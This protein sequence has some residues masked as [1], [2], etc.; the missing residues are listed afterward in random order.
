MTKYGRE[1]NSWWMVLIMAFLALSI[2]FVSISRASLEIATSIDNRETLRKIPIECGDF[3]YKLPHARTLPTSKIY[4]L[5]RF[6]DW[7]WLNFTSEAK[8]KSEVALFIAD[9]KMAEALRLFELG[10][11]KIALETSLEAVNKLKYANGLYKTED[12]TRALWTYKKILLDYGQ[13][14]PELDSW[15]TY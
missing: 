2:L 12:K 10:E 6:R 13:V 15:N 14:L 4:F 8:G 5:K 3:I 11:N 7:L 1:N 9:K